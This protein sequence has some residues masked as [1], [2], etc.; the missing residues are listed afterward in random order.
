MQIGAD[1]YPEHWDREDWEP[2][3]RLMQEGGFKI[4]RLAEFAWH[5]MEPQEGRFDFTWLDDAIS[6]L[7]RHDIKVILGTPTASPP[8][9]VAA[10]YPDTLPVDAN[11][12]RAQPGGRRHYC[13]TSPR[14]R[15]LSRKIG[16]GLP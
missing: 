5:R 1:Y 6:V 14:Y 16:A 3:A 15:D 4:V 12:Q 7:R 10:R 9:W 2:H 8:P 13:F 11:G